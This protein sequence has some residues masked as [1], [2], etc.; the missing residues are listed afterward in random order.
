MDNSPKPTADRF[1]RVT[2]DTHARIREFCEARDLKFG[3]T[4]ERALQAGMDL[5]ESRYQAIEPTR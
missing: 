3:A 4:V 5:I 2:T 1:V